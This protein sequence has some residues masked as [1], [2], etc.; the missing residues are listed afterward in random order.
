MYRWY[1]VS[2]CVVFVL[3]QGREGRTG[4]SG[5][6]GP[7]VSMNECRICLIYMLIYDIYSCICNAALFSACRE[8]WG[9]QEKQDLKESLVLRFLYGCIS[10]FAI[11]D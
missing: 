9:N 7:I 5:L 11:C 2:N 3:V 10:H 1:T 4:F 6:P 8:K